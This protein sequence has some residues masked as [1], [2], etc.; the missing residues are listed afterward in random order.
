MSASTF[1][2]PSP[3]DAADQP[4]PELPALIPVGAES[5]PV[6]TDGVCYL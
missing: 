6:C 1:E 5:A 2:A 4:D 3:V